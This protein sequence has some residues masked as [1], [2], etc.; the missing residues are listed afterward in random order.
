MRCLAL[1]QAWRESG[2][3][4][5]FISHVDSDSLERRLKEEKFEVVKLINRHP[6]PEDLKTT[7]EV[8]NSYPG[9]WLVLD[10]YR[11]DTEYQMGIKQAG[12]KLLVVDDQAHLQYY[13]AD[14]ILN[15][16]LHA[17]NIQYPCEPSARLLLGPKYVLLRR[18]F[19]RFTGWRREIPPLARKVLVTLGGSDPDNVTA[20]MIEALQLV[21]TDGLEVRVIAG[22]NNPH[23]KE[24]QSMV[25]SS[26]V[27]VELLSNVTEMAGLMANADLAIAAG[28]S[29]AWELAFMG[30]PSLLVVLADNQ[31]PTADYLGKAGL[32]IN[33]GWHAELHPSAAAGEINNLMDE[34]EKRREMSLGSRKLIDGQ[35]TDR[36]LMR[37]K[38]EK[39]RLRKVVEGDC[40]L[41]WE[42]ANDPEVRRASF[43]SEH[44]S[45]EE[46]IKWFEAKHQNRSCY[47]FIAVDDNDAP[48]GLAR[49]ELTSGLEAEIGVSVAKEQ[50]GKGCGSLLISMATET[51]FSIS[52]VE[53]VHAFIK[54]FNQASMKAFTQAGFRRVGESVVKGCRGEHF[55]RFKGLM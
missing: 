32:A 49:L 20:K 25:G 51:L 48:T 9:A 24:L 10:G 28:G 34:P 5:V 30:L 26:L 22:G 47:F 19:Q 39:L 52:S 3:S 17:C 12:H 54:P 27:S 8:L 16:N 1:G 44:I 35:G 29:T 33:L 15:Q 43:S 4:V 36:V 18:E 53:K 23:Y 37:L 21:H 46:H 14:I 45:W 41:I 11:F 40:R 7:L 2:G 42:W 31:R 50:R 6:Y 55:I 13:Y 38:G